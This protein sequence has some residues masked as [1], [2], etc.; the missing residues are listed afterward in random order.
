MKGCPLLCVRSLDGRSQRPTR[1]PW[2][3]TWKSDSQV[4]VALRVHGGQRSYVAFALVTLH[5]LPIQLRVPVLPDTGAKMTQAWDS[6]GTLD[7]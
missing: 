1:H 2:R 6:L 5:K 3:S 4:A 7:A